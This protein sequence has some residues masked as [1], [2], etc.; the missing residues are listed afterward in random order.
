MLL[1]S[2]AVAT[3][4]PISNPTNIGVGPPGDRLPFKK[5]KKHVQCFIVQNSFL[6]LL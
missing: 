5:K 1:H 3:A 4:K 2:G 6:L